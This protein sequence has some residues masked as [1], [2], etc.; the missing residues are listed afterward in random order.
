MYNSK[1]GGHYNKGNTI[2]YEREHKLHMSKKEKSE[3]T[4][5]TVAVHMEVEISA[6]MGKRDKDRSERER[7]L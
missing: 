3:L 2:Q 4:R 1:S 5:R 6:V 7:S